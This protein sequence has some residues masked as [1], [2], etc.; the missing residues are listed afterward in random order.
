MARI[1]QKAYQ[2]KKEDILGQP[3]R[4]SVHFVYLKFLS[5]VLVLLTGRLPTP[6]A[7]SGGI[8]KP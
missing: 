5:I 8:I 4:L 3:A 2:A 6:T 1:A 7:R